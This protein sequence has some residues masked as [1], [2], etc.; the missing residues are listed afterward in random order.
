MLV[1]FEFPEIGLVRPEAISFNVKSEFFI[2]FEPFTAKQFSLEGGIVVASSF[3]SN[4]AGV[5]YYPPPWQVNL[6]LALV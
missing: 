5:I 1:V 2:D 4:S 3:D 6:A